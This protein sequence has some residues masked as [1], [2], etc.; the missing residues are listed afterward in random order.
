MNTHI[1]KQGLQINCD[2]QLLSPTLWAKKNNNKD[3]KDGV[4]YT[5]KYEVL[6]RQSMQHQAKQQMKFLTTQQN[7]P[8]PFLLSQRLGEKKGKKSSSSDNNSNNSSGGEHTPI[9]VNGS[10]SNNNSS[11]END[12][13]ERKSKVNEMRSNPKEKDPYRNFKYQCITERGF[14]K[15]PFD[16]E[17]IK[18]INQ[19]NNTPQQSRM[20]NN[21]FSFVQGNINQRN[22]FGSST[23]FGNATYN[24]FQRSPC[25][26]N[27]SANITYSGGNNIN[28]STQT[29]TNNPMRINRKYINSEP[30]DDLREK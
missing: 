19:N 6:Q 10:N 18:F 7:N 11:S 4:L 9:N 30:Y 15:Y 26:S 27:N 13:I 2:A 3:V 28:I 24:S 25:S 22:L 21:A 16:F 1:I 8:L 14:N 5:K 23:P 20:M 29:S 12:E 17:S